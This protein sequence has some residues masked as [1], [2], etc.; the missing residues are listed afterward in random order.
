LDLRRHA[1]PRSHP[2]IGAPIS[3]PKTGPGQAC[4]VIDA[5]PRGQ[6]IAAH[7]TEKQAI[8]VTASDQK[9]RRAMAVRTA[10]AEWNGNLREGTGRV[11]LGS[12]AFE[13]SYS[14]PSRFESG[15]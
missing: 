8:L 1:S 2:R 5:Q 15:Q 13:G 11:K 6:N 12:G 14:F 9:W 3:H 4:P 7:V 10:E